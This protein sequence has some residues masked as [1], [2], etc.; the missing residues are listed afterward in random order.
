MEEVLGDER[1]NGTEGWKTIEK[2]VIAIDKG[3]YERQYRRMTVDS[4]MCYWRATTDGSAGEAI[5]EELRVQEAE[6]R[7]LDEDG[8]Y[9]SSQ[10]KRRSE[11]RQT[12]LGSV[13]IAMENPKSKVDNNHKL[14]GV[15]NYSKS[16]G[17]EDSNLSLIHI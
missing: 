15:D 14:K 16:D 12:S 3:N 10:S 6:L 9:I 5:M 17:Q 8:F 13:A 4:R 2:F 7:H 1:N 11:R